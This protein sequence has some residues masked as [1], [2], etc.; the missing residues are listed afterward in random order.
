MSLAIVAHPKP[1]HCEGSLGDGHDAFEVAAALDAFRERLQLFEEEKRQLLADNTRFKQEVHDSE[2]L[3]AND[4][5]SL[6]EAF[7]KSSVRQSVS[8]DCILS[9]VGL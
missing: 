5:Q 3:H 6:K 2:A 8:I 4:V 1:Q 9:Y 7:E